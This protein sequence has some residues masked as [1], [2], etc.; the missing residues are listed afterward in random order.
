MRASCTSEAYD[1]GTVRPGGW[2]S[3]HHPLS[4]QP[5][6]PEGLNE[7]SGKSLV[8]LRSEVQEMEETGV[9][10]SSGQGLCMGLF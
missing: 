6:L 7:Y 5:P 9:V 2:R 8:E 3:G 4:F 10:S 1:L